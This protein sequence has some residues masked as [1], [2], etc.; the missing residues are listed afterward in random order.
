MFLRRS[1]RLV[2]AVLLLVGGV[3]SGAEPAW[4]H[5]D[6]QSTEPE[7]GT[8]VLAAPDRA[9]ARYDLPVAVDGALF[10]AGDG[11]WILLPG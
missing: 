4:A 8:V 3:V 9:V 2:G 5:A 1:R 10:S 11:H 6:L 7:Y